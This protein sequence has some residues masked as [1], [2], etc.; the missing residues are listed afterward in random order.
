MMSSLLKRLLCFRA[1]TLSEK[2][3]LSRDL[4][5]EV[6]LLR[7]TPDITG[8]DVANVR[9]RRRSFRLISLYL[10]LNGYGPDLT[11]GEE[12]YFRVFIDHLKEP[13]RVSLSD[14]ACVCFCQ[15]V[16]PTD[17][18]FVILVAQLF[19]VD[20]GQRLGFISNTLTYDQMT[21]D[22]PLIEA[23]ALVHIRHEPLFD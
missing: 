21:R 12:A 14:L 20:D 13:N 8:A 16:Q 2:E 10:R 15:L 6:E 7:F 22:N 17:L 1:L 9:T 23:A 11:D 19:V 5:M 4:M 18:I 3:S